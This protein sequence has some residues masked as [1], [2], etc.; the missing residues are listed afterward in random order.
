MMTWRAFEHDPAY[1]LGK[2]HKG[3]LDRMETVT[4]VLETQFFQGLLA[5]SD[6]HALAESYPS[7][8]KRHDVPLWVYLSSEIALK[9]NARHGFKAFP[10]VLPCGGLRDAFGP[11]QVEGKRRE[12][13]A[14]DRW[15]GFNAKNAYARPSPCDA[16]Y[17][18]KMARDTEPERLQAWH[19]HFVAAY[20][21]ALGACDPAG[22]FLADGTYLFVP[23]NARY[24]NSDVL[25][26]DERNH[27]IS[28]ETFHALPDEQKLR[29]RRRR[30]YRKVAL[31]HTSPRRNFYL[32]TGVKVM[33]GREAETPRLLPLAEQFVRAVGAGGMKVL[34]FD[35]G[36]IDG[37]TIATL[38]RE[39][40]VDSVFPLKKDM[41]CR[42]EAWRLAEFS[43]EPWAERARAPHERPVAPPER[44]ECIRRREAKRQAT[45]EAAKRQSGKPPERQLLRTLAKPIRGLRVWDAWRSWSR[46]HS[47]Q[48]S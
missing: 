2:L 23:D 28:S 43:D 18:R 42:D 37:A 26:F 22:I 33:G 6:F 19:N 8:R 17:L 35:R 1:V 12:G 16:D 14:R 40:G 24:E 10:Y 9:I 3:E 25:L 4:R 46:W 7:P 30:C 44:P 29:V 13:A 48:S 32:Y 11:A 27:P 31:L 15:A 45:V 5:Q 36:L 39:H 34:I 47:P 20:Y 38:K 21:A 41:Q